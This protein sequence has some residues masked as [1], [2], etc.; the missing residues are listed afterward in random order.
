[1]KYTGLFSGT[2]LD[3]ARRCLIGFYIDEI[4]ID[5]ILAVNYLMEAENS[6]PTIRLSP[7]VTVTDVRNII[8]FNPT[9]KG[10]LVAIDF[11]NDYLNVKIDLDK[12]IG[13]RND[14]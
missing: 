10:A 1:M 13:L 5:I 8:Q 7:G 6:D 3:N 11:L 9:P 14:R 12:L 2:S 4:L